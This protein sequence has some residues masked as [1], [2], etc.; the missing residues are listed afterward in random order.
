[1]TL[2]SRRT[3][4][5][6]LRPDRAAAVAL[7]AVLGAS[8][9]WVVTGLLGDAGTDVGLLLVNLTG[10]TLLAVVTALRPGV[11]SA[12]T[13]ALLSAGLC[14]AL[15][16]WSSLALR[17]ATRIDAGAWAPALGWLAANLVAGVAVASGVRTWA[18]RSGAA[19][20]RTGEP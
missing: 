13:T 20:G 16:T 14:G 15:T 12:R 19:S 5:A 17:T 3:P 2:R 4:S 8:L 7:G 1:M 9:R 11:V 10:T 6:G 18:G